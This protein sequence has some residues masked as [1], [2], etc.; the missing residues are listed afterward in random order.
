MTHSSSPT[1][2]PVALITGGAKRIGASIAT[3]LHQHRY[4]TL[5]HCRHSIAEAQALVN[6]LNQQRPESA[7]LLQADLGRDDA[8]VPLAEQALAAFGQLDALINNASA[9]YPTP[10]G[11][12]TPTQWDELMN[13]NAKA[14]FFLSQALAPELARRHGVIINIADIHAS[15]PLKAHTLYCMAKAANLM[16]TQSLALELAPEVRVNGIAPGA[17]LWPDDPASEMDPDSKQA[18]LNRVPL[19]RLGD[20]DHIA[21]SALF[22]LQNDY[23]SGQII[24]V[25]GGRLIQ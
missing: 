8:I 1:D 23:L 17:I 14:P 25:D 6:H 16:L 24:A 18:L 12:A 15:K 11:T 9:F 20:P 19:K 22:L 4:R 7:A 2:G 13:S 3:L 5:I 21:R 10:I